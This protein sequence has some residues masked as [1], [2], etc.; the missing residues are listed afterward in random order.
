MDMWDIKTLKKTFNLNKL[1]KE[2]NARYFKGKL[3]DVIFDVY[4]LG[5]DEIQSYAF[6]NAHKKRNG[7]YAANI[8]FNARCDW[9][10]QNIRETLLHEM[11]HYYHFVLFGRG[12]IFGHGIPFIIS[13]LRL[14]LCHGIFVPRR[15]RWWGHKVTIIRED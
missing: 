3:G 12:L 2:Y 15:W 14:L 1:Y 13:Q 11:I 10:E 8:K 5:K 7:G 6:E 9:N 4:I